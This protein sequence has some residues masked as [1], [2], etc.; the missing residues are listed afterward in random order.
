M[1]KSRN[2]F[3][4][5]ASKYC[6]LHGYHAGILRCRLWLVFF[7]GRTPGCLLICCCWKPNLFHIHPRVWIL[8][9]FL[10]L[11]GFPV[12]WTLVWFSYDTLQT[13]SVLEGSMMMSSVIFLLAGQSLIYNKGYT[14]CFVRVGIDFQGCCLRYKSGR[15]FNT[16][17]I[18]EEITSILNF[19]IYC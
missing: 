16:E 15:L 19:L 10:F 4:H 5:F 12:K 6:R 13:S 7:V 17:P 9:T 3:T 1:L 14:K 8:N 18:W 2:N 11:L